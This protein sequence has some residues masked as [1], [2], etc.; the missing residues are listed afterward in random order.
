MIEASPARPEPPDERDGRQR[1]PG[2]DQGERHRQ[3]P[4]HGQAEDGVAEH[5]PVGLLD[6][7]RDGDRAEEQPGQ[8]RDQP[9]RLLDVE[10]LLGPAAARGVAERETGDERGNE[11]VA[12]EPQRARVGGQRQRQHGGPGEVLRRPSPASRH[13]HRPATDDADDD[14]DREADR[15]IRSAP[16]TP[17]WPWTLSAAAAPAMATVTTGVAMPSLSPLSTF[18]TRR[19]RSG[20]AGSVITA[21]PSAASV[22][23]SAA[24][25]SSAI[26][27][28]MP[29]NIQHRQQRPGGDG[30]RQPHREQACVQPRSARK[31]RSRTR[32][33]S[34]N[35]TQTRVTS[36]STLTASCETSAS[37]TCSPSESSSP[38]RDEHDRRAQVRAAEPGRETA[39]AE[40]HQRDQRDG[41]R[42]HVRP[43]STGPESTTDAPP[44]DHPS[45]VMPAPTPTAGRPKSADVP[46]LD[47]LPD[48]GTP[49]M[50]GRPRGRRAAPWLVG[51]VGCSGRRD[52]R[53]RALVQNAGRRRPAVLPRRCRV[54]SSSRRA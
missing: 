48:A 54:P 43:S 3:H 38:T 20:T 34:A 11:T 2:A 24:P 51:L 42:I 19:T 31:S 12:V 27:T 44:M 9:R 10:D 32:A 1:Q 13:P 22:G 40:D 16:P 14:P 37:M 7:G 8:Q 53:C 6:D 45:G 28:P 4:D 30:E 18:S 39:P 15:Q 49:H 50:T 36:A 5:L 47:Y 25:T 23:A 17:G 46:C 21:A 52:G 35:S 33:A 41:C 29:S 26:Q